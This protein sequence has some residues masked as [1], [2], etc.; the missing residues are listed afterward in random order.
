LTYG[1][2]AKDSQLTAALFYEDE[3]GKMDKCNPLEDEAAYINGG[4][5]KR[6]SFA[7]LSKEI[8][9]MGR[10]HSDI[11]FQP[12][13]MLNEVN[14]NIKLTRSKDVFSLCGIGAQAFKILITMHQCIFV[15]L[16]S[17]SVYLAYTKTL[18][19]GMA[20][21]PISRVIVKTFT[22]PTGFLDISQEKL[23]SGQLPTRLILGCI[24]NTAFNGALGKNPYNFK[25]YDLREICVLLDGQNFSIKPL[26]AIFE[27]GQYISAYMS[28]F[29]AVG[30]DNRDE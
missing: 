18:E 13:Y 17:S 21:Y 26:T 19:N 14:T 7:S 23:V 3:A 12:R 29:S 8:D 9:L 15:K 25:N 24:E 16:V 10:I 11:F 28:M 5:F 4:L 22:I 1:P 2:S 30:K 20:K 6:N 27:T